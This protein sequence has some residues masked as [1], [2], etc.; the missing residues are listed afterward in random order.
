MSVMRSILLLLVSL[1]VM[2]AGMAA[3]LV[4][5]V[6]AAAVVVVMEMVTTTM[7]LLFAKSV[8]EGGCSWCSPLNT[9]S[10]VD[11]VLQEP[12]LYATLNPNPKRSKLPKN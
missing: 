1:L 10:I 3:V 6:V 2:T 4:V 7:V 12:S 8:S 9:G 11:N 5:V